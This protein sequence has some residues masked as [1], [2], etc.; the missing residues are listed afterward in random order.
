MTGL[1]AVALL[2]TA[3]GLA[4]LV[5]GTVQE[6]RRAL[7]I[8]LALGATRGRAVRSV[9]LPVLGLTAVGLAL[10][11]ALGPLAGRLLRGLLWGV[12]PDSPAALAVVAGAMVV[13]ALVSALVPALRIA[14]IDPANSLRAE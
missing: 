5:G 8:S 14:H 3:V 10:G 9:V 4:G 7:G 13:V 2:L 6:R 12:S 1:A 11:A